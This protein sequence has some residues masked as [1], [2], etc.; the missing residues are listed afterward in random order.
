M[1]FSTDR[2]DGSARN[3]VVMRPAAVFFAVSSS[4]TTSWLPRAPSRRDLFGVILGEIGEKVG[5]ASGSLLDDVGGALRSER[6]RR[7]ISELGVRLHSRVSAPLLRRGAED[8]FA[9]SG[10]SLLRCPQCRGME[11]GQTCVKIF[12]LMRRAGSVSMR[13]TKV[14][15]MV[16]GGIFGRG[17]AERYGVRGAQEGGERATGHRYR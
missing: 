16:R 15:G 5:A 11:L 4:S 8:G 2:R 1:A 17:V 6:T 3:S 12:S 13:S 10:A 9:L 7:W 14:Q